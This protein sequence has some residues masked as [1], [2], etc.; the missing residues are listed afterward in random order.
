MMAH[1]SSGAEA[2]EA[3]A[4]D[5]NAVEDFADYLD[6]LDDGVEEEEDTSEEEDEQSEPELDEGEDD[7]EE[8]DEPEAPAIDPP[9]SWG[10]DAKELFAQLPADLQ[11]QVAERETQRERFVQQ[12]AAEAAEAK[13]TASVEAMNAFAE[14]QRHYATELEQYASLLAPQAPDPLL[15][16]QDPVAF[17]QLQAQ[18]E[19]AKVQH[20][21]MVQR[22]AQAR[23]E[24][25]W[26]EQQAE[27]AQL[28][29]DMA[30]LEQAIP[31]WSDISK[32]QELLTDVVRI[33]ADLGYS[34]EVMRMASA[35]DII[36]LKK[37]SEWKAKAARFDALQKT[38][39]EK[40]R[41]AKSLP[42]VVKPG[43]APTRGEVNHSK[44]DR[45]WQGVKAARTKEQKADAFATY[46]ETSGLV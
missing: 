46:L 26:R 31:E 4:N 34:D 43:V 10:Q 8:A 20:Q 33:G 3:P 32:R 38:K 13:R 41:A 42:K 25:A 36:A 24:A 9:V 27:A 12:K 21:S 44:S 35:Q 14:T 22:S 39:M 45:A 7:Q 6:T 5:G 29:A 18:Y 2:S 17:Y 19:Q 40:V 30:I 16:Q 15:L 37:A 11:K 28:Q 23:E 1:P